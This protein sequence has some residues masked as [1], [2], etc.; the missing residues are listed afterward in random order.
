MA[1]PGSLGAWG[2]EGHDVIATVAFARLSPAVRA[3]VQAIMQTDISV[4]YVDAQT[5]RPVTCKGDTIKALANWADCVRYSPDT[6]YSHTRAYHFDD[7]P[8]CG[9][10]PK[11]VYCK[12]DSCG[13]AALGR[14][15]GVLRDPAA[16]P[17]DRAE[18]L[19]FV[20]HIVGDLHQPLHTIDN[21]DSG[22][23][24]IHVTL[25]RGA[26]A[27]NRQPKNFH[28]FWDGNMVAAAVGTSEP[29]AVSAVQARL[30]TRGRAW[31]ADVDPDSWVRN[32]HA[33]ALDGYRRLSPAPACNAHNVNG[34]QISAAYVRH[35][36]PKVKDQLGQAAARLAA[37]LSAALG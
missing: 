7:V 29:A 37:V 17:R 23:N 9:D 22:G 21:G 10:P 26:I 34:G 1:W 25:A 6:V 33:I 3:R 19:A 18:A 12:D 14:Y 4:S 36:A 24:S 5:H 2:P 28:S 20:V 31:A 13:S 16:A 11:P 30:T 32:A 27:G 8:F 35:F 15:L